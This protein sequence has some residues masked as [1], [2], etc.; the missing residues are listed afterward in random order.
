MINKRIL[1]GL[2]N[3]EMNHFESIYHL[4]HGW[5][6]NFVYTLTKDSLT[7]QDITQ[8]VFLQV[9]NGRQRID[10]D[11]NFEGYLFRIARNTVYHYMRRE[12]MRL[13]Y[14]KNLAENGI[15]E[16]VSIES[17]IDKSLLEDYI[18]ELTDYLPESRRRILILYWK[19][20]L[21]YKE[22]AELL[23][24]S[25]KTVATQVQ[26]SLRFFRSKLER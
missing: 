2:R 11:N 14:L 26:R 3:G 8:D 17:D 1:R 6:Y 24:I 16:S 23:S 19:S 5:V 20:G 18:M 13:N 10:C 4:Y 9:W 12:L 7:A 25:E 22:I 15:N 21:T